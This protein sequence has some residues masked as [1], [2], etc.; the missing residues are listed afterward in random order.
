MG[1]KISKLD[2]DRR[3]V[4]SNLNAQLAWVPNIPHDSVPVGDDES[5]NVVI[6]EWGEI[7]EP[8]FKVLPHWE[9]G[10]KLGMLDLP[11]AARISGSGFYLM[12]GPAAQLQRAL[13]NYML[14]L[15]TADGYREVCAPFIVNTDAMFGTAQ[16]P[17][18]DEDM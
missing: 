10:E 12:T 6:R 5:A 3:E 11:A 17:K 8:A 18:M 7:K 1:E 4:E 13:I 15:H 16:L 9:L 14:D 2:E